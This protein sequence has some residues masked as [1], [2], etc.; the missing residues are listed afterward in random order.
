MNY[1]G[2]KI[3]HKAFG[4]GTIIKQ[5]NS[6]ISIVF[7]SDQKKRDFL[8]PSCFDS[9]ITFLDPNLKKL[10]DE[11]RKE[12]NQ[13]R[14]K[15]IKQ[16]T[17][18]KPT[19][20]KST[21]IVEIK[22]PLVEVRK[23]NSVNDFC[24][25]YS[26]AIYTEI[27]YLKKSKSNKH[28]LIDGIKIQISSEFYIYSFET[29][30]ELNLTD[31]TKITIWQQNVDYPGNV[32][33][34]E[35]YKI[36][37][38][39]AYDLGSK[40][41]EIE[42]S[43]QAWMLLSGLNERLSEMKYSY[44][45]I[46][47]SLICDGF[48]NIDKTKSIH[49]GQKNAAKMALINPITFIWGPPGTGKTET[50]AKIA[51]AH[52]LQGH[53]VLM[54]SYSNVSVDGA[55][56]RVDKLLKE[57]NLNNP[58]KIIRYGNARDKE[59]ISSPYLTSS[60][61]TIN[62]H[63]DLAKNKNKLLKERKKLSRDSARLVEIDQEISQIRLDLK[64]E[65]KAIVNNADFVAT[66]VSMAI[67]N[68]TIKNSYYDVVI[69]DEASMAYVPQVIYAASLANKNFICMGDFKQLP[70]I[71]QSGNSSILNSDIFHYCGIAS[72][73]EEGYGH[74]WLC[75][76]D[77]QYR[78]NDSIAN[79]ISKSFYHGLLK[80]DK[81]VINRK[82]PN[83]SL[84]ENQPIVFADLSGMM[85]ICLKTND[86][87]RYNLL[88]A[89]LSISMATFA[90]D[91]CSIGIITPYHAQSRLLHNMIRDLYGDSPKIYV[92]CATVHQFQGSEKD[93]IIYDSVDCYRMTYPSQLLSSS[94]NGYANRLFN[95]AMTRSKSKFIAIAN[96]DYMN[97]K[98]LSNRLMFKQLMNHQID[99][100]IRGKDLLNKIKPI[101][102][103]IINI[104]DNQ[105]ALSIFQSDLLNA[106]S[107]IMID[108]PSKPLINKTLNRIFNT[109]I[110]LKN[111]NVKVIIRV[112]N[113]EDIPI[114]YQN[115]IVQN[116]NAIN[117]ITIID[118]KY[119]WY[120]MPFSQAH[121]IS[122]NNTIDTLYY[123]HIR[124]VGI[125][126]A[127]SI[128]T[129]LNMKN[130][131]DQATELVKDEKGEFIADTFSTYVLAHTKCSK[132]GKPMQF[133]KNNKGKFFLG[134]SDYPKCN[135]I[136]KIDLDLVNA[137]LYRNGGAGQQCPH[138]RSSLEAKVGKYGIYVKC[139]GYEHHIIKLDK[140]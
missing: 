33:S 132:C 62:K 26:S 93:I 64:N 79:F 109:L 18:S 124:F 9:F 116:S 122:D 125:N 20:S 52:M 63:P 59:L 16:K 35:D 112:E 115:L 68:N 118:K 5:S 15:V 136:E 67:V 13:E 3:T 66:T 73:V 6:S 53:K 134:C 113:K 56:L 111:R 41:T 38:S 92:S 82:L 94:Q 71:V 87:S 98:K 74:K 54:L 104:Y 21:K 57:R 72:A 96:V 29:D 70:P 24:D 119:I 48:N 138:C 27:G 91:N 101:D 45:S 137:Y 97:H 110:Q 139:C 114:K 69:F 99:H 12:I 100:M 46:V 90:N 108:I 130:N 42:I 51:I 7:D 107:S 76:L 133:K 32:I 129:L 127:R 50:L 95:V 61:L 106:E 4:K 126:T 121:F 103:N 2:Q 88:S 49:I 36:L 25:A 55:I 30:E 123:P 117:P 44:S 89:L 43:S 83:H 1:I 85:S 65:E 140:I 37:L 86:Q 80:S 84:F 81:S 105:N 58:G 77:T 23:F 11:K 22:D 128:Y 28:K 17:I 60:N 102:S 40:I 78:M 135:N 8:Y 14:T 120:G 10:Q 31:G 39:T 131:M 34:C 19:I 47:K 75:M